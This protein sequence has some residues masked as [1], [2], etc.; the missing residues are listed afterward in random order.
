MSVIRGESR[1]VLELFEEQ[2]EKLKTNRQPPKE[3]VLQEER[4]SNH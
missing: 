4:N 3:K 1:A 2:G